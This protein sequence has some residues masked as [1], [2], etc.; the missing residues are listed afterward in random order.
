MATTKIWNIRGRL[1]PVLLYVENPEKTRGVC[2]SQQDLGTLRDV[3]D[4]AC[5]D[6]KT[7]QQ[8]YV[9]GINC[10]PDFARERIPD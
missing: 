6:Y 3:M 1:T 5:D 7:E 8:Y 9:T 2:Y 4:Y 10:D